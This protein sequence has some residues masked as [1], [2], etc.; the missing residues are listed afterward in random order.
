[1]SKS[2]QLKFKQRLQ[3]RIRISS[4][5]PQ[6]QCLLSIKIVLKIQR[7]ASLEYHKTRVHSANSH[8]SVK[9]SWFSKIIHRPRCVQFPVGAISSLQ[10]YNLQVCRGKHAS[11]PGA[12]QSCSYR[13]MINGA[14][15]SLAVT[16]SRV[17]IIYKRRLILFFRFIIVFWVATRVG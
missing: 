9:E 7:I 6:P 16:F 1:M 14:L 8:V 13:S 15:L 5:F 3:P 4:L 17:Y 2:R 11:T 12:V 10:N